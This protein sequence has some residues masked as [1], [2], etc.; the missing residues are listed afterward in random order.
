M[1]AWWVTTLAACASDPTKGYAFS[2]GFAPALRTVSVPVWKNRT[3]EPELGALLTEAIIK[4]IQRSTPWR[5][6]DVGAGA[7]LT[8]VVTEASLRRLG[9]DTTTGLTQELA[10]D[11]A[12]DFTWSEG[13]RSQGSTIERRG[14]RAQGQFIPVRGAGEPIDVGR[15]AALD[16]MARAIVGELRSHW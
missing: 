16:A 6:V 12:V 8:G 3:S 1:I 5:V 11:L 10:Y 4:E 7:T 2:G 14:F 9:R 15:L 13:R